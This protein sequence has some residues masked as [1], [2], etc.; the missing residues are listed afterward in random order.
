MTET[1]AISDEIFN[2]WCEDTSPTVALHLRQKL[3]PVEGEEGVIFPPTYADIGY[4]IDEMA[5]G[6]KVA[7]IDSVGSQANR[8]EPLFSGSTYASLVPQIGFTYGG[9]QRASILDVGHRL[10]D[11]LVRSSGMAKSAEDAFKSFLAG[12]SSPIA[13]LAPTSLLFGVWDSRGTGAK[14]PRIL[15]SVIRAWDVSSLTRSAVYAPPIDYAALEVFSEEDRQKGEHDKKSPLAQRGFVH[16]PAGEQPGG[17]VARGPIWRDTTV[18]LITLR[19]LRSVENSLSLRR[20]ILGL[21]LVAATA[22]LDG[23][24]RQGCLLT[25]DPAHPAQWEAVGRS[26]ERRAADLPSETVL[27]LARKAAQDFQVGGSLEV[28]F[29]AEL[30]KADLAAASKKKKGRNSR[31]PGESE[32]AQAA[33]A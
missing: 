11:A 29:K 2:S 12:D 3:L 28:Q 26:G 21:A 5:D 23:F 13:K 32:T 27:A 7:T 16:N 9:G 14:L 17:I 25:L 30:A 20:Y 22:P 6:T 10:G 1:T 31:E 19:R 8:M 24:L 33:E 4:N 18:N 15:Q